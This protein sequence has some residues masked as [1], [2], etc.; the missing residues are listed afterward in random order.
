MCSS[1]YCKHHDAH[2]LPSSTQ[3][4]EILPK[5]YHVVH[6]TRSMARRFRE[7]GYSDLLRLGVIRIGVAIRYSFV[8]ASSVHIERAFDSYL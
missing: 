1:G 2:I 4:D 7:M 6:L 8:L 3:R 5:A